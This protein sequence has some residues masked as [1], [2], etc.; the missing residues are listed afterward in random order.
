MPTRNQI[1]LPLIIGGAFVFILSSINQSEPE[2]AADI[3]PPLL[4][5]SEITQPKETLTQTPMQALVVDL[6]NSLVV[7]EEQ[8]EGYQRELFMNNWSD[9]DS[10]GCDTRKEVLI[11]ESLAP[12]TMGEAC[13]VLSGK[14]ISIYDG[15]ETTNPQELDVDHFVPL[16][17]A[18]D[19]GAFSWDQTTR[20]NF[21]NDL[22]DFDT[23]IAVSRSSNRNKSDLD[24][25]DWL[26]PLEQTHCWYATTWVTIKHK[27]QLTIDK[28]ELATLQKILLAC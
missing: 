16:A 7:S 13:K 17:E 21:A 25:T 27:W 9:F 11:F 28:A 2:L 4:A 12:V 20:T 8:R 26:P 1:G 15:V 18:W 14:W 3:A 22:T 10:D 19:S 6:L 24:P 5:I 23:L